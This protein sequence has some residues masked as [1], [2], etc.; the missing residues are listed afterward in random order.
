M[1]NNWSLICLIQND[2]W[3]SLGSILGFP[4]SSHGGPFGRR[5][6]RGNAVTGSQLC[7]AVNTDMKAETDRET[8]TDP[9]T[10]IKIATETERVL[11]GFQGALQWDGLSN[12]PSV[13]HTT[14]KPFRENE[15]TQICCA[16]TFVL[17]WFVSWKSSYKSMGVDGVTVYLASHPRTIG[18]GSWPPC[19]QTKENELIQWHIICVEENGS[20]K[21]D[22]MPIPAKMRN[23][24]TH[25]LVSK[26]LCFLCQ[27][28]L[29]FFDCARRC[30]CPSS[31]KWVEKRR[32]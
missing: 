23:T 12:P 30:L 14:W 22:H 2:V 28:I 17:C 31:G 5:T 11:L 20:T 18:A 26:R 3:N 7:G 32:G 15:V 8:Q 1:R 27:T 24:F 21:R 16:L 6:P 13:L 4:C 25:V 19:Q 9:R 29:F 10:K